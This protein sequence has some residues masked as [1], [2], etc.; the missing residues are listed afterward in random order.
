MCIN[1]NFPFS[2][3]NQ[4]ETGGVGVRRARGDEGHCGERPVPTT[5]S[6]DFHSQCQTEMGKSVTERERGR[7]KSTML[8][9]ECHIKY[10]KARAKTEL[11]GILY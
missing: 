3:D 4:S 9:D 7:A 5:M 2:K 10:S 1:L 11:D 6:W 8:G